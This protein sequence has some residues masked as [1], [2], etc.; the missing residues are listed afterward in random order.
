VARQK[1]NLPRRGTRTAGIEGVVAQVALVAHLLKE[2][3]HITSERV[4]RR[5]LE[6]ELRSEA[7]SQWKLIDSASISGTTCGV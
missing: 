4:F 7:G 1:Q 5:P 2:S 6:F 3:S